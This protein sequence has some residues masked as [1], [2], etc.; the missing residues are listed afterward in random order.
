MASRMAS[1]SWMKMTGPAFILGFQRGTKQT[2]PRGRCRGCWSGRS[3][4]SGAKCH[5]NSYRFWLATVLVMPQSGA[6]LA[7]LRSTLSV[8]DFLFLVVL[9]GRR[10]NQIAQIREADDFTY[11]ALRP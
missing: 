8:L 7:W 10:I 1:P 9:V 3:G 5:V 2:A 6:S 11:S 4:A